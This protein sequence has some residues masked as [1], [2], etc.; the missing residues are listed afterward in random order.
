MTTRLTYLTFAF[1]MFAALAL[2]DRSGVAQ[3]PQAANPPASA[4]PKGTLARITVHGRALDG[5]L[6]GDPADR[7]VIVYLPPSYATAPQR[8]YPVI[9]FLH[10]YGANA[11]AYA[12]V[13]A[14]PESVD[15][16]IAAGGREVIVVLPDAFTKYSGSMYSNS[17]TTGDWETFIARDLPEYIDSHYRTIATREGRGLSGHS[18]GGYGTM[19][20]GMKRPEVFQAMYAMS[21]CCLLN[22][23]G[24]ARGAGAGAA[25]A[26]RAGGPAPATAAPPAAPPASAPPAAGAAPG[27]GQPQGRA[28][29]AGRGAGRGNGFANAPQAQAAAWA[30]NPHNPPDFFDMPTKDGQLQPLIAAKYLANSPL[31]MVDQYVPAL[32]SMRGIALDVG[33]KDGLNV[34]N[35]QLEEALTRLDVPH[36]FELYDGDHG[37]RVGARF[38]TKLLPFFA[39]L[40]APPSK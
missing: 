25:A 21:S 34:T 20:I 29:G 40:L 33:D 27:Q 13:L 15:R 10:G 14:L 35:K 39:K 5:N 1:V 30:P 23:P 12:R 26:P 17:V 38:E 24:A 2:S 8:R 19:R 22:D 4:G 3:T 37:N 18:M 9:Y 31:L 6:E 16:A 36:T 7:P 28:A 32:R 11:E